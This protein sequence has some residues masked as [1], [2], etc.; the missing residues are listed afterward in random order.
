MTLPVDRQMTVVTPE[1]VQVQ[2]QTAGLGSRA[3]AH[4]VDLAILAI[5]NTILFASLYYSSLKL[6]SGFLGLGQ[7][8][9]AIISLAVFLINWGYFV[10]LEYFWSGQT[11][12]KRVVGLKV[13]QENGQSVT[14][15]SA[16][17]RNLFRLVD[18]LPA[19][20]LLGA[21]VCFFHPQHKRIGDLVA[22]TVVIFESTQERLLVKHNIKKVLEKWPGQLPQVTLEDYHKHAFARE[23]WFVLSA[24]IERLATL[25]GAKAQELSWQIAEHLFNKLGIEDDFLDKHNS[26]VFLVALYLEVR[27]DYDV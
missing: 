24:F 1:H 11:I 8:F 6:W 18:S 5:V 14:F 26:V 10:A 12:G 23:D 22:G 3:A 27:E 7:Y 16:I 20:Y 25:S 2:F 9:V 17:I 19:G 4:I 15:L 13:V 21:L